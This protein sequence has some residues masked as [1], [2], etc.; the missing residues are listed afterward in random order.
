ME[1]I[2]IEIKKGSWN[3]TRLKSSFGGVRPV[4]SFT[5]EAATIKEG[6][7]ELARRL[8][9]KRAKEASIAV[10][11]PRE[12]AFA[13]SL[14]IPAPRAENISGILGFEVEKHL[15]LHPGDYY[16]GH[17]VIASKGN[18][19]AVVL[20]AA[21]K[22]AVDGLL[23]EFSHAGLA[24]ACVLTQQAALVNSLRHAKALGAGKAVSVVSAGPDM[25]SVDTF[26]GDRLVYS[27]AFHRGAGLLERLSSEA[28]L[29]ADALGGRDGRGVDEWLVCSEQEAADGLVEALSSTA[30]A[31]GVK[32]WQNLSSSF[33]GSPFA[34][35]GALL[36]LGKGPAG[37]ILSAG[38]GA[39]AKSSY[40]LT[41]AAAALAVLFLAAAGISYI[42]RDMFE[43]MKLKS[44]IA[45]LKGEKSRAQ[46]TIDGYNKL[47]AKRTLLERIDGRAFPGVL[48]PLTELVKVL[49][50]KTRLT[51]FETSGASVRIEGTTESASALILLIEEKS[52]M[53]EKAELSGQVVKTDGN[54][55][56]FAL[57][58]SV[59]GASA[60]QAEGGGR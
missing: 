49:P 27:K 56:R 23:S 1:S 34:L 57:N 44:S 22:T 28:K 7:A 13:R 37:P 47:T 5:I 29:A 53:L 24:P 12:M 51:A 58:L 39:D 36:A 40:A 52:E 43:V 20:C 8:S 32:S 48:D 17:S 38:G 46:G 41:A 30:G 35:G 15:P 45:S 4:D 54:M 33:K 11:L 26:S 60:D 16:F 6:A 59:R 18:M 10:V 31:Q 3:V 25:V 55:E 14:E 21:K 50:G 9:Q 2:G 19:H 42:A